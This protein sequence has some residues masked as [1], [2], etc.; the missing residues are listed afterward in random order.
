MAWQCIADYSRIIAQCTTDIILI[1]L[2]KVCRPKNDTCFTA[3][4]YNL[5]ANI[6][7]TLQGSNSENFTVI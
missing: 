6:K 7:F 5:C 4:T 2:Y 1:Q 3:V